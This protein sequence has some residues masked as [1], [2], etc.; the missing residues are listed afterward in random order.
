MPL[1]SV[2]VPVYNRAGLLATCL[3]SVEQQTFEKWECLIV[4][5]GSIDASVSI[6]NAFAD[7]DER[8]KVL[9]RTSK[10]KGA[11]ACRNEGIQHARGKYLIFLDSDDLLSRECLSRRVEFFER[12]MDCDFIVFKTEGFSELLGTY[13]SRG[14]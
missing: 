14:M 11:A 2:I 5:D 7:R 9:R 6:A 1:A 8:F 3:E 12:N 13:Q 10:S 4:D